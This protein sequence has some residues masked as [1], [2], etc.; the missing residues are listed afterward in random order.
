MKSGA[1]LIAQERQE[2]IEKHGYS[3]EEDENINPAGQL[4]QAAIAVI[5]GD[6]KELPDNW[7]PT[8]H[9]EHMCSKPWKERLTIAGAL[10]AAEIDRIQLPKVIV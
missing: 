3:I 2:Q 6:V 4:W 1:E 10:I 9:M 5:H 8:S 7:A